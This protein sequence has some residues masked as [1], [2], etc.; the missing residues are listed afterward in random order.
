MTRKIRSSI[1]ILVCTLL[2]LSA[3]P[4]A[5]AQGLAEPTTLDELT[6]QTSFTPEHA[7]LLRLYWAF[8]NREPDLPGAIYWIDLR[9]AGLSPIAIADYFSSSE[10][11]RNT[12]GDR[13]DQEFLTIAYKN[14]LGRVSDQAGFDYWLAELRSGLRRGEA[15]LYIAESIEFRGQHPYPKPGGVDF[16][17]QDLSDQVINAK[18]Y[19][20]ANFT[21]ARLADALVF[22]SSFVGANFTGATMTDMAIQR[23]NFSGANFTN[24]VMSDALISKSSNFTGAIWNNTVCPDETNS[25]DNGGTCAGHL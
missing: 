19:D 23:S 6:R 18:N 12:Y 9:D 2:S 3:V 4:S 10:E 17:G 15:V 22:D 16:S 5:S 7:Q 1:V 14:I 21:N 20:G 25:N 8:F 11:F 24:A 13:T